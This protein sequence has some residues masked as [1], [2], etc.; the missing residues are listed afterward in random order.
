MKTDK[1]T[2]QKI[3][4]DVLISLVLYALPV[5]LMLLSFKITGQRP[6]KK[7]ATT[8]VNKNA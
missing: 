6:W 2:Q 4:R 8:T 3:I 7:T 5:I 1:V